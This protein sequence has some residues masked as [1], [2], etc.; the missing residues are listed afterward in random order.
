MQRLY[1]FRD[2]LEEYGFSLNA[3]QILDAW[4]W[5]HG[6]TKKHS[7][8]SM[9]QSMNRRTEEAFN[10]GDFTYGQHCM[11]PDP[12]AFTGILEENNIKLILW[13]IP[14]IKY[15]EGNIGNQLINDES[16][17]IKNEY[18]IMNDD[19]TP[20]RITDNWFNNSLVLDF[21]N[22]EAVEWWFKK[23][24]Y[25]LGELNVAAFKTDGGEF[26]YDSSVRFYDGKD[27]EEMHNL[28][29]NLYMEAY[30]DFLKR[31]LRKISKILDI[32]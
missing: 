30:H 28:Y 1:G 9:V 21:T 29:P 24:E 3:D 22:P 10:Y 25:L 23:R 12:K 16:H 4:F 6:V 15:V 7:I 13:Q 27:G 19:L 14:V 2:T 11:W 17:A 5:N 26:V 31:H 20:Y 32:L 18:C 8:F